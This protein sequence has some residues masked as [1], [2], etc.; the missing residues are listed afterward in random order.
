MQHKYKLII[1]VLA[2][3]FAGNSASAYVSKEFTAQR[4]LFLQVE[5]DLKKGKMLSFNKHRQTLINYPL[6]PYLKYEA[7]KANINTVKHSEIRAFTKTYHDSPLANKLR[8]DWLRSKA[9]KQLWQ[10]YLSGYDVNGVN[11]VEMQCHYINAVLRSTHDKTVYKYIPGIWLQGKGLPKSCDPVFQAWKQDGKLTRNLLW[12]RIKLAITNNEPNLARFLAKGLPVQDIKIVELWIRTHNDPHL[13]GKSHY[14]TAK[15]SAISE[16][17]AH[18][19][20][21]IAKSNPQAAVKLWKSLEKRHVF[22]EQHWGLVIKEIGLSLS[23]NFDPHAEKWLDTIP[24]SLVGKEVYDARLKMAVKNNAWNKIAK[25]Y[26]DLPEDESKTEKWQYWYARA[27]EML[28]DRTASQDIL[29]NLSRTRTYYGFLASAR[30]LKSFAFNHEASK[31]SDVTYKKVLLKRS[32]IRAHELKQ[33]GRHHV[34]KTEW[35]KA[36]EDMDEPQRLAAA[37]LA[38]E[39]DM[40]N[41]AITALANA[42]NKNDLVLRFPKTYSD[43]FHREAK[44]NSIDPEVLFAIT[45]QESAFIE[46]AR[47]PVGALGLMQLMPQTGKMVAKLNREIIR[48]HHELLKPETNI[49]LGSKYLRMMLDKYQQN[50]ALA[51]ASY[52]AGPHRVAKWIPEY[53]M[54]VDC[55][56][57]TIPYKETREY[58]QNFLTYTV[59]YQQ[60]LGKT[61]KLSKYM[62][63]IKG[64]KR[65]GT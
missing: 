63:I 21:K 33:I 5:A 60:L 39:W 28:G 53:D 57:E 50:H 13:I 20:V 42:I 45:R 1:T 38:T 34:G 54:P 49:R 19:I 52:N 51:A 30:T 16:M 48:N 29:N 14:F 36:L 26:I 17:I 24:A 35:R 62:P 65:H 27:L 9:K 25:A 44:H 10:D 12:Q 2:L 56:I 43:H 18:A 37:H 22:N 4:S 64:K 8:N 7:L 41:W 31:I 6:Y 32:V 58:V 11:D 3:I 61:P 40:P 15:H 46:T 23:R 59:I 55:W 47:S